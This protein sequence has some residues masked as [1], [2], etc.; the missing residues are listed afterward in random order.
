MSGV[1]AVIRLGFSRSSE[2][3]LVSLSAANCG[4]E[5]EN[6]EGGGR[7]GRRAGGKYGRPRTP[8]S[9]RAVRR[10]VAFGVA[11]PR[12]P[13]AEARQVLGVKSGAT[14]D[15]VKKAY[16]LKIAQ[17]HPDKTRDGGQM[18]LRVQ[19]AMAALEEPSALE[20]S[21][22][23]DQG[24]RATAARAQSADQDGSTIDLKFRK[25]LVDWA[26][27]SL[28]RVRWSTECP[29]LAA[30]LE[31]PNAKALAVGERTGAQRS[32]PWAAVWGKD[33]QAEA[34]GE[35]LRVCRE[36][37]GARCRLVDLGAAAR[38]RGHRPTQAG[39]EEVPGFGWM[40]LIDPKKER[41][42]GYK[43]VS[44]GEGSDAEARVRVPVFRLRAGSGPY[45]YT[46]ARPKQRVHLAGGR[47]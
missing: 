2:S 23:L 19:Q 46:P 15:E 22:D 25:S 13:A 17:V 7:S 4:R 47:T 26:S 21:P 44:V 38:Q 33:S 18:L 3:E 45:Y 11:S 28:Q 39:H 37:G 24:S 41:L 40:P 42:V 43:V 12:M 8:G 32:Q 5:M 9:P 31:K 16:R 1:I 20:Q 10:V 29:S 34:N 14:R 6:E 36:R 27:S 30:F 35:A